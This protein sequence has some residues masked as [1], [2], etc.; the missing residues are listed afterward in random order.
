M[1]SYV[2]LLFQATAIQYTHTYST[3]IHT[4]HMYSTHIQYTHMMK[5][6]IWIEP[7]IQPR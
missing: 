1:A 3:F 5:C 7:I 6:V 2:E 4:V